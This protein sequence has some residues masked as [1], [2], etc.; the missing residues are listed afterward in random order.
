MMTFLKDFAEFVVI[1]GLIVLRIW[2]GLARAKER[3][4][5]AVQSLF[6]KD[7]WWRRD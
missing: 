5:P 7:Q 6:G 4:G 3:R 1:V 2:W